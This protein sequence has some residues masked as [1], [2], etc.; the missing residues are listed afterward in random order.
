VI[1]DEMIE[2]GARAMARPAGWPSAD[3]PAAERV[4]QAYRDDARRVLNGVL[5]DR[6]E[7]SVDQSTPYRLSPAGTLVRRGRGR[8]LRPACRAGCWVV[9]HSSDRQQYVGQH[10]TDQHV[11]GWSPLIRKGGAST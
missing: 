7:L 3:T 8:C 5:P 4:R 9:L 11:A 10:L 2:A 6:A 1:A